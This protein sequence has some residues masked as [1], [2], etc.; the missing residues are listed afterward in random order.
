MHWGRS[1]NQNMLVRAEIGAE[2]SEFIM[3]RGYLYVATYCKNDPKRKQ[4]AFR[5]SKTANKEC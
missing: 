2:S 1:T 3:C 4:L 5:T